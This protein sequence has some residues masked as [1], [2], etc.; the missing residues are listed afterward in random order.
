MQINLAEDSVARIVFY[1]FGFV[2]TEG[3]FVVSWEE[4][5]SEQPL[6]FS[7]RRMPDSIKTSPY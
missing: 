7:G 3:K 6:C 2:W 1:L 4:K 5:A